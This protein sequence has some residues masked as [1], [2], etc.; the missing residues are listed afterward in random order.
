MIEKMRSLALRLLAPGPATRAFLNPAPAKR[1]ALT[2]KLAT[3]AEILCCSE[4][5]A[6]DWLCERAVAGAPNKP[7]SFYLLPD[8]KMRSC[9]RVTDELVRIELENGRIFTGQRSEQKQYVLHQL[10]AP[11]INEKITG[12]AYKLAT[13]I[14]RRYF[15]VSLHWYCPSGG[16]YVE[17]GCFTGIKAIRWHDLSKKPIQILAVEIGRTNFEILKQNIADNGLG[18]TIV[19]V[20]AGLWSESGDGVQK[21]SFTTRHFLEETDRWEK[22]MRHTEPV[23]LLTLDDLLDQYEVDVAS[24]VNVQVNGAEIK[25]LQGLKRAIS[26]IKVLNIAS[27]YTHDG[28]RNA[29]VVRDM[30]RSMGCTILEETPLGRI[31][32]VTPK[33]KDEVLAL[34][35]AQRHHR[36]ARERT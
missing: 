33:Y 4:K 13:D 8:V 32:A 14:Q 17:G 20:H 1:Q 31:A 36:R 30:L 21:H 9:E 29:D 27:Y 28:K 6:A 18:G 26:K 16:I 12:D 35:G 10:F 7:H 23:R 2:K 34:P 11:R 25:V 24:F 19:P 5:D 15:D 3:F 22:Q